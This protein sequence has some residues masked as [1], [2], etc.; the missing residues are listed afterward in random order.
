MENPPAAVYLTSPDYL[1]FQAD[2]S[3]IAGVCHERNI[4]LLVDNAHGAYL[5]FLPEDM[6]PLTHGADMC[7]D[8]AHKTL[9]TLTGAAYLHIHQGAPELFQEQ[10]ERGMALFA[11]T[12]PSWLIL[13][14]L[15]QCNAELA[16]DWPSRLRAF[17]PEIRTYRAR[18]VEKGFRFIGNEPLKWTIPARICGYTGDELHDRLRENGIECE[19][20]DPDFLVM[21]LSPETGKDGLDRLTRALESI[22]RKESVQWEPPLLPRAETALP[23]R[24][25]MLAPAETLPLNQC[26]GR[27]LA[28]PC[29]SCPPAVPILIS[30]EQ[31]DAE[32]IHCFAYYGIERLSCVPEDPPEWTGGAGREKTRTAPEKITARKKETIQEGETD[33]ADGVL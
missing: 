9:P 33:G 10:A 1:G 30:G 13:Q 11:S 20:S 7:C 28:E 25:A 8:S 3:G 2:I 21:M 19:F 24:Q 29:V 12:S 6:H 5:R 14:S 15:D 16:E 31:I 17:L 32:A 26:L 22:P 4:P 23:F 18:L 27:I